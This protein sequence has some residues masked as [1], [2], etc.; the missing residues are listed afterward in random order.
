MSDARTAGHRRGRH[1]GAQPA[2]RARSASLCSLPLAIAVA[3][4]A[5]ARRFPGKTAVR[6]ARPPAA[7][8]AAGRRSASRCC[9][10]S[11]S[12]ARSAAW[13]DDWFGIVFAFRW[14]GAALASA[15]MG[16]PLMVR[17]IRLSMAGDRPR[18]SKSP[19][20][21]WAPAA[22]HVFAT[23]HA[24]AGAARASSPARCCRS[25][26]A[27]ANS[28]RPSPSCR[29]FP[30]RR[31]PCRS[32]S[33]RCT[34]IPGGDWQALRLSLFAVVAV[35]RRAGRLRM[36]GAALPARVGSPRLHDGGSRHRVSALGAF[37]LRRR[38]RRGRRRCVALFGRSG[39]GKTSLV[40]ALAGITQPERGHIAID[41]AVL[42]DSAAGI[43]LPP[44]RRRIGYV[45]QDALLF[46]HLSVRAQPAVR[47]RASHR[48]GDALR[49]T[50]RA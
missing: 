27:W 15:I 36:A 8:A 21:R 44:E 16:F 45:F 20:A 13:L 30:A 41:G 9:C 49:S 5:G 29:T 43:D 31:R 37:A 17:A 4:A 35:G 25:R 33:T 14:T 28:A 24:A 2:G 18:G 34:Q 12:A 26:A 1:P 19:R 38:V 22:W 32:R 47:L 40:N 10:C 6:R 39:S 3:Y 48:A 50:P 11:A 7:G 42:F 46:P 23:H